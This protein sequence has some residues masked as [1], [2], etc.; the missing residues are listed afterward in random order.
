MTATSAAAAKLPAADLIA[1]LFPVVEPPLTK[2]VARTGETLPVVGLDVTGICQAS[3]VH[4]RSRPG[5]VLRSFWSGGGRVVD[6]APGW[7][8]GGIHA[9]DFANAHGIADDL[10]IVNRV[11]SVEPTLNFRRSL[12]YGLELSLQRLWRD[13]LD[14][15]QMERLADARLVLPSLLDWKRAALIRYIGLIQRDTAGFPA[16]AALVATGSLDFVQVPYS[17]ANRAAEQQVFPAVAAQR[18]SVLVKAPLAG[19]RLM[20]LTQGLPLPAFVAEI[21]VSTWAGFFLKWV[22]SH[23]AVTCVLPASLDPVHMTESLAAMR[24]PLPGAAMRA[25]MAYHLETIPG[26]LTLARSL[27]QG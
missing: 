20:Q 13:Q 26:F 24:G 11:P 10:F 16:L 15:M 19:G 9:G 14:V 6:T 21:G 3:A 12:R 22:V 23:P 1:G 8:A 7:G 17:M 25:R 2:E 27:G 4:P 5:D 18:T